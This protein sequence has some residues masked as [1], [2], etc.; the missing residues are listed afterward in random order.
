MSDKSAQYVKQ[1]QADENLTANAILIIMLVSIGVTV[2]SLSALQLMFM[3][4]ERLQ[5]EI[6]ALY[7]HLKRDDILRLQAAAS[8]H[9]HEIIEGSFISQLTGK[10]RMSELQESKREWDKSLLKRSDDDKNPQDKKRRTKTYA[11]IEDEDLLQ[12][13]ESSHPEQNSKELENSVA[14]VKV[15]DIYALMQRRA[16]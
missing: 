13:S 3:Q 12:K 10:K 4:V 8:N 11:L 9:M 5:G 1:L 14:E 7:M 6:L 15:L 16:F 2:L